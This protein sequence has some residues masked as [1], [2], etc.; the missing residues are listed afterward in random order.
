VFLVVQILPE[1]QSIVQNY[2][3]IFGIPAPYRTLKARFVNVSTQ[4]VEQGHELDSVFSY[5]ILD[6]PSK[7]FV[8]NNLH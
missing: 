8:R 6:E 7:E 1:K 2:Y 3:R 4:K 5:R